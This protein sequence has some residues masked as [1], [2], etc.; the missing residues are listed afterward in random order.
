MLTLDV[1]S[2]R[3]SVTEHT[4]RKINHW[5]NLRIEEWALVTK[6]IKKRKENE[7][8][9]KWALATKIQKKGK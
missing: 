4:D 1:T 2:N 8:A 6:N 9:Q 5:M 3:I 7:I